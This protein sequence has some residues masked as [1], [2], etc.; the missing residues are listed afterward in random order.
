MKI[1]TSKIKRFFSYSL[2]VLIGIRIE[3]LEDCVLEDDVFI[4][5]DDSFQEI[6]RNCQGSCVE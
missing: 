6:L 3:L 5:N 2:H 1:F 4:L